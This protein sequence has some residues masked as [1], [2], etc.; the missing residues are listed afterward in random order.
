[1]KEKPAAKQRPATATA[2]VVAPVKEESK[3][4][5]KKKATKAKAAAP[6]KEETK[7]VE[8]VKAP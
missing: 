1:M 6:P 8:E 5:G 7:K 3:Q 4:G 2:D